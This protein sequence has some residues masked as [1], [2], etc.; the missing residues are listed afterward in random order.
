[1]AV[2]E[3]AIVAKELMATMVT[4]A[5]TGKAAVAV[6]VEEIVASIQAATAVPAS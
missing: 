2:A 4:R 3:K 1:M 6:E 5:K